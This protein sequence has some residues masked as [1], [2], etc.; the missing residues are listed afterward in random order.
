M[1]K[2][3]IQITDHQLSSHL[4]VKQQEAEIME[5]YSCQSAIHKC[6]EHLAVPLV[7]AQWSLSW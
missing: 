5:T 7:A 1:D 4:E 6:R 3:A 2:K